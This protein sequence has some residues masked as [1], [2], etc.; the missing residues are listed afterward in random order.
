MAAGAANARGTIYR[1]VVVQMV[2]MYQTDLSLCN[3][4]VSGL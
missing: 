2:V 4:V 3:V 1:S